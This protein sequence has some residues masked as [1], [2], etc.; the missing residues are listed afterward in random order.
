M[1]INLQNIPESPGIYKFFSKKE[2]I[3]IGKAK[4]LKKRVSSYFGKSSKDRKTQQIKILTDNIET[5]VTLNEAQAL[6]LEQSLIK[7]NLPRFNILLRDDKTYPY[8]HFSMDH[9]FPSIS[10][11]RTKHAV[12]K[13]FIGPFISVQAVKSTIK[14][15]RKIYQIRNCSDSTFK[16]RSRPCIEHQMKRCSAPC[17]NLIDNSNYLADITSAQQYLSSSSQDTKSIMAAKMLKLSDQQEF[18]RANEIKQKIESLDLIHQEQ[19]LNSSLASVDTFA[20][21]SKLNRTGA[22]IIS[23]RNGKIRG[24]KSYYLKGDL[25]HDLDLLFQSLIFS[26]YQSIFS[27]PEKIIL[28]NK[29]QNINLIKEAVSLK[30][31]KNILIST[32][33]N[34]DARKFAKLAILNSNQ[35]IDNRI[36]QTDRYKYAIKDLASRVGMTSSNLSIE[37]YDISHHAGKYA[38]ASLVK[39][40]NQGPIKSSYKIFNMPEEFSGNDIGSIANVLERRSARAMLEPLPDIILV[41]G[42]QLQLDAAIR[43]M[44]NASQEPPLILCIMKGSNR[45]RATETIL[46]QNGIIEMPKQSAGF[47]LLQQV[48]DEAHRFAIQAHRKK[49]QASSKLSQLE[50]IPGIGTI[51]RGR[52]FKKFRTISSIKKATIA[53]LTDIQ[54]ISI[55][56]AKTILKE[57]KKL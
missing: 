3:Y 41:D 53:D 27:L 46:S 37:G 48:R 4:N 16:N 14:D 11:R 45:V 24:V 9:E 7:E 23:I 20:C 36:N 55:T 52:L 50:M 17:V 44:D 56:L 33:I 35:A 28:A 38:V 8:V 30:F 34:T 21:I 51:I 57:L 12:S 15:L 22:A 54:G 39:F 42:G 49:K 29:V 5:F 40:S 18:E 13:N 26:Y 25:T 6:L 1:S 47:T 31:K 43:V 32:Y 19:S 2:I 10:M